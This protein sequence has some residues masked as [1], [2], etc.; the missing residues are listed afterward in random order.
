MI[1]NPI[2]LGDGLYA[3][4]DGHTYIRLYTQQSDEVFLE[5]KVLENFEAWVKKLREPKDD[6]SR[7]LR[8]A[9]VAGDV[10]GGREGKGQ[11]A[12]AGGNDDRSAG[13]AGAG[14][15][16]GAAGHPDKDAS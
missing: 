4:Y 14:R 7:G 11:V 15:E 3:S 5:A 10:S 9:G 1:E 12:G 6:V 8:Q 13:A 2:Y 16:P